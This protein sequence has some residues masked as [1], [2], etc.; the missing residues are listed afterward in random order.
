M[1]NADD[2]PAE[3]AAVRN[4]QRWVVTAINP[5]NSRLV[6][7]RLDDNTL[8]AFANDYVREH[9][10]H[11]YAMTVHSA[12]GVTADTAHTVLSETATRA[13][14]YVAMTRGHEANTTYLYER[15]TE[16]ESPP[17]RDDAA[18]ITHRANEQHAARLLRA[19]VANDERPMTAL[20]LASAIAHESLPARIRIA[21]DQRTAAIR[22][23]GKEYER[24]R[25]ASIAVD[26]AARQASSRDIGMDLSN[27]H[28]LEI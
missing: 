7:R 25:V 4:G 5:N 13:M 9:I 6:A 12:Q 11:G 8:G 21:I 19:I 14:C 1:R 20:S 18:H 26:S 22:N 23:R 15:I 27:D 16:H 10:T 3:N 24:W 17:G 28:G 2:L